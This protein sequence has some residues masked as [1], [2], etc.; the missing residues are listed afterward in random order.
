M[1]SSTKIVNMKLNE[2]RE[3]SRN[4]LRE[5]I[6]EKYF[7]ILAWNLIFQSKY[8]HR[9]LGKSPERRWTLGQSSFR[10]GRIRQRGDLFPLAELVLRADQYPHAICT[11]YTYD[12]G[13]HYAN[14]I[15]S[16]VESL[17]HRKDPGAQA[18]F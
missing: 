7:Q 13:C 4:L 11:E 3:K 12:Y 5:I 8:S 10:R 16:M 14:T 18:A 15:S 6:H 1:S 17:W 9:S 2:W